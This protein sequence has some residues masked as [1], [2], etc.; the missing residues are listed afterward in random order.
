MPASESPPALINKLSL[1]L[2]MLVLQ[3]VAG[4]DALLNNIFTTELLVSAVL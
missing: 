2:V 3:Q 4:K 1:P